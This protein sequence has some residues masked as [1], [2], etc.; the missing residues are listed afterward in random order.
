M[1]PTI[2]SALFVAL[3]PLGLSQAHGTEQKPAPAPPPAQADIKT[4]APP[5][6]P[7]DISEGLFPLRPDLPQG[8]RDSKGYEDSAEAADSTRVR[9]RMHFDETRDGEL[10]VNAPGYKA[11]F[12]SDGFTYIPF[13]GSS[14]PQNYPVR[15]VIAGTS[16]DGIA[17]DSVVPQV[18]RE[19][20][21]VDIDRG[22]FIERYNLD[23]ESIEQTFVIERLNSR[24]E[25]RIALDLETELVPARGNDGIVLSGPAG[26]VHFGDV[27]V[28]DARGASFATPAQLI[29][30]RIVI[31]VDAAFVESAELPLVVDPII[32]SWSYDTSRTVKAPDTAYDDT[33]Q[34]WMVCMEEVF[35][36]TDSDVYS[37]KRD[38]NG[39]NIIASGMYI[40]VSSLSW[41]APRIA[42]NNIAN[43][44]L[45]VAE[46]FDGT[47]RQVWGRMRDA[48]GNSLDSK[49]MISGTL[50]GDKLSPDV[51]GDPL[52]IG[53]TYY[54]VV[55]NRDFSTSD[56]DIHCRL[57]RSNSTL[58]GSSTQLIDNSGSTRDSFPSISNSNGPGPF[59][60]QRWNIVWARFTGS[61]ITSAD[62]HAAQ[63]DWDGTIVTPSFGL[64]VTSSRTTSPSASSPLAGS[65]GRRRWACTWRSAGSIFGT[66]DIG[67]QP[68]LGGI[69]QPA[70]N[71][72]MLEEQTFGLSHGVENQ[73]EPA[74]VA[75]GTQYRV[76]YRE[77]YNGSSDYDVRSSTLTHQGTQLYLLEGHDEFA[78][79]STVEGEISSASEAESGGDPGRVMSVWRDLNTSTNVDKIE[80]NVADHLDTWEQ[81]STPA[82]CGS[83]NNSG[84]ARSYTRAI[85]SSS[86]GTSRVILET[87]DLPANAFGFYVTGRTAASIAV[88]Q[89]TLCIGQVKRLDDQVQNS[90]Q[91]FTVR[92]NLTFTNLPAGVQITPGTNYFQFW[93]R[94]TVN[95]MA[96]SNLSDTAEVLFTN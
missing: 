90:A 83:A 8:Q 52:L 89:G 20:N 73:W 28:L 65:N 64:V 91:T 4:E 62:I 94:D 10:W 56:K 72:T 66:A 21:T 1:L 12:G 5:R 54:C 18:R 31:E 85:G 71:L 74:I 95:N 11:S 30:G 2:F 37:I 87:H 61:I 48:A 76:T 58:F 46:R 34:V 44:F 57:V 6:I 19:G 59:Q 24:G 88:G 45:T 93:H 13:L 33:N 23:L 49:F 55:W 63:L 43:Q 7:T 25:L 80:G 32:N 42:N 96:T 53:P 84:G 26:N 77:S 69:Q 60:G 36:Q 86:I 41:S 38:R 16:V 17:L 47:S 92:R 78:F 29:D 50:G 40:D 22:G 67:M 82:G 14:A 15:F 51:G 3:A 9:T 39:N 27:T 68:M 70:I 75:D 79:S 35:S 81:I